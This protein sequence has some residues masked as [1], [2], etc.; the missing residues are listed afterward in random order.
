[1]GTTMH[2]IETELT[3]KD[4]TP[5]HIGD[6]VK[7]HVRIREGEKERIQIFQ[8]TVIARHGNGPGS[9]F[10]VR[11]VSYAVGVER[12]FPVNS[13][14]VDKIEV[15]SRHKVRRAKLYFLRERSGKS[16]RLKEIRV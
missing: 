4:P 13:P 1:M 3:A 14:W 10:T 9:S 15:V 7:V 11:K 16:A 2:D 5:I 6:T 8:G 12:I